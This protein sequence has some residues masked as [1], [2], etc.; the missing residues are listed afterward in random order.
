M[1]NPDFTMKKSRLMM[2]TPFVLTDAILLNSTSNQV[3]FWSK[4]LLRL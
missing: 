4:N 1:T 3:L 2:P